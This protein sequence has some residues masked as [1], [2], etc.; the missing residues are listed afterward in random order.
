VFAILVI[1]FAAATTAPA[2]A[3]A[4]PAQAEGSHVW[5]SDG[6]CY[7]LQQGRWVRMNYFRQFVYQNN[8]KVF[9]L[10]QNGQLL[11]RVDVSTPGWIKELT[12]AYS[13]PSSAVGWYMY[14]ANQTP[15]EA[16]L[17]FLVKATN[18]WV[19]LAQLKAGVSAAPPAAATGN[20]ASILGGP[21]SAL[22]SNNPAAIL[23]GPGSTLPCVNNPACFIGGR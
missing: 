17:F 6:W 15:N 23:G 9:D 5:G 19:S 22:P 12:P 2:H 21:G 16:N 18:Q 3:G 11:K 4:A 10:Y 1:A 14:P 7:V 8:D 20:P 13:A